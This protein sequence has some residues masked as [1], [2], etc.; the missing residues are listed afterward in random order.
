MPPLLVVFIGTAEAGNALGY[1]IAAWKP[2]ELFLPFF[3]MTRQWSSTHSRGMWDSIRRCCL[4]HAPT[5]AI[6]GL[7]FR[8]QLWLDLKRR[9]WYYGLAFDILG[10]HYVVLTMHFHY[11]WHGLPTEIFGINWSIQW[12][13]SSVVNMLTCTVVLYMLVVLREWG[14]KVLLLTARPVSTC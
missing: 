2:S 7:G 9:P 4:A 5:A 6:W 11:F 1:H 13:H 10:F 3:S 8:S 14:T 12:S